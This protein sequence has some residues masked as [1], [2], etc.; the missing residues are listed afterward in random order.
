[1]RTTHNRLLAVIAAC[2]LYSSPVL[3]QGN[4]GALSGTISDSS[5][6]NIP[7]VSLRV[8]NIA[9]GAVVNAVS[10]QTGNYLVPSLTPGTYRIEAEK[11]GFRKTLVENVGVQTA[12]TG[13]VDLKLE[14]GNVSES[15]TVDSGNLEL[16][17][18]NAEI[19][20]TVETKA[21]LDLP[22]SLG[23]AAQ[24]GGSGRRQIENF[25]FLTPGVTGDQWSKSINGSPAF[26]TEVLI[27]GED[28]QNIG[29]PGFIAD[30][31]PPYE[32]ISEFKVQ[33]TLYP[34]EY[35]MGYGVENFTMRSGGNKFHGDLFEL[36]R[37]DKLD[38]RGFFNDSKPPLRQNEFGGTIGGPVILPFYRGQDKTHFFFAYSGFRLRGGLPQGNLV[39]VP[40][41]KEKAGDF[42]DYPYPIFDP[43]STRPDGSGSFVRDPFPGNIIPTNRL[44]QVAQRLAALIPN[45]DRPGYFNNYINRSSQPADDD[46]ISVKIDHQLTPN[47]QITGSLWYVNAN[48]VVN[49]ELAGPLNPGYRQTPSIG[50]GLR[51]NHVYTITPHLVNHFGFGYTPVNPT[52]TY[53]KTDTRK[54]NQ[55]LKIPGIPADANGYPEFYFDNPGYNS[56]GNSQE[57]GFDPQ[58]FIN[59]VFNEDLSWIAGKHTL[60]VGG[61]YRYRSMA[62]ADLDNRA[63]LFYT[64]SLATSQ[65]NDPNFANWGNGFASLMLGQIDNATRQQPAPKQ[66]FYDSMWSMYVDDNVKLTK[67]L[68]L[69]LGLRYE[70]PNYVVEKNGI[71]SV[72]DLSRPNPGAGNILGALK[73]LGTGTGRA[74]TKNIFGSYNK[75]FSPRLGLTYALDSKTVIRAGYGMFRLYPNYG[76]MN[77]GIFWNS[78]FGATLAVAST[79][80]GITPAFNLDQGFPLA[81]QSL[82]NFDPSQNNNGSATY[83]NSNAN[84]PARMQSWTL[85]VQRSLPFSILLDAAY[86][87]SRTTGLPTGL[88]NINQVNPKYLK[89]G[90]TLLAD[91]N[92][93]EAAAAGISAPYPGFQGSVAQAL[94]PY[95]QYT[96]IWDQFQPTGFTN[97]NALQTKLQKNLSNGLSFLA[98]YTF[99]K[100]I[101]IQGGDS[102][103]DVFGGGGSVPIDTYNR[104]LEKALLGID[105]T[106]VFVLSWNLELPFGRGKMFGSG[107]NPLLNTVLGGWQINSIERYQ[108]G[109][110]ISIRGGG[111]IPLFGNGNRPNWI[112]NN[113]R[114]GVSI[115][116]FDPAKDVY[117]NIGAFSQPAPYTFGNAPKTLPNVRTPAFYNE[118]FSVFKKLPLFGESRSIEFRGEFFNIFNRVVFGRPNRN[119]NSPSS[120]GRIG[121][122]ANEP[123]VIQLTM[124]LLF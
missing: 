94:R 57:N 120:F 33:N 39:S 43:A 83:V 95:P 29:A 27:D 96:T 4:L 85:D 26:S 22:I 108:S 35:G 86:V 46:D 91:I 109:N 19:G 93:P 73:F 122:Q 44:S 34:A 42:S 16:Q 31:S 10:N 8:V 106:H 124:K 112:S 58:R 3:A 25:L 1:M 115:G 100:N 119:I 53:W 101:G 62:V 15:V 102:F 24:T 75:A 67:R 117:L 32:A 12:T 76:R 13:T 99:S 6:A 37:N 111:N 97:Y 51:L 56:L 18:V 49:G 71:T 47:Q 84:R 20:T 116:N 38:A 89:L 113:V 121:S 104:K 114:S 68:T 78:G 103:G 36:L 65:P 105:Q 41:A 60:K 21:I 98:S 5:G 7:D 107:M 28:M 14:L 72:L 30:S 66:L 92:S 88:E 77:S 70:L 69:S 55:V 87:G 2:L 50:G 80:S 45:P 123:R 81:D 63:G 54:G 40:T 59:T 23:G 9:T 74:G 79:N 82:P 11:T 64:T 52:W 48:I 110:P 17:T 118:D 90:G 61:Q